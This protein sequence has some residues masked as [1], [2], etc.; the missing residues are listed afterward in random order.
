MSRIESIWFTK[1]TN[2]SRQLIRSLITSGLLGEYQ[3]NSSDDIVQCNSFWLK[4]RQIWWRVFYLIYLFVVIGSIE[5]GKVPKYY[6]DLV[7][8]IGGNIVYLYLIVVIFVFLSIVNLFV[9]NF[10]G[11]NIRD[12]WIIIIRCLDSFKSFR[13]LGIDNYWLYTRFYKRHKFAYTIENFACKQAPIFMAIFGFLIC[14]VKYQLDDLLVYGIATSLN[15]LV[16][17][18]VICPPIVYSFLTFLIVT[19]YCRLRFKLLNFNLKCNGQSSIVMQLIAKHNDI[20]KTI[21]RLDKFWRY[22]FL[23][24]LSTLPGNLVM[25][26]ELLFG[27]QSNIVLVM[28]LIQANIG[29]FMINFVINNMTATVNKEAKSSYINLLRI[30]RNEQL[31]FR[32]DIK[33]SI[34]IKLKKNIP[35]PFYFS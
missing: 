13:Y 26:H 34:V 31:G 29:V 9:F 33:V 35:L 5:D 14:M 15:A 12:E 28:T 11:Q 32:Y 24:N 4:L 16:L 2:L 19:D 23:A 17:G 30:S 10:C 1:K 27:S 3:L 22:F 21:A 8:M 6:M 7:H 18:Y 20:C 25:L